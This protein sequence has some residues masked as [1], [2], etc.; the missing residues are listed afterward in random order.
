IY[1]GGMMK[2]KNKWVLKRHSVIRFFYYIV[3]YLITKIS[4]NPKIEKFR[5]SKKRQFLILFNHQTALDQFLVGLSVRRPVYF[6]ASEDIFSNGF[7]SKLL[8][9]AT[10]PI[11]IKKSTTDVSAVR[12]CMRVAREGGTIAMAPEGNRTY[13]GRTE[14]I[15]PSVAQLVK[16]LKLP[17]ALY[18]I[19]GGYGVHPRFADKTRKGYLHGGVSR[20]IEPE[21][22]LALDDDALY[23]II[24]D[25]LYV[26]DSELE[27]A[28]ESD[29]RAEYI[30]RAV[31]VCPECGLSEFES[32]KHD[33]YCKK[34]G[35]RATYTKDK[36]FVGSAGKF[37]FAN[38]REWYDYQ[39]G[40]VNSLDPSRYYE[41]AICTEHADL[42]EVTLYKSKKLICENAEISLFGN[43]Y[44][45]VANGST[46]VLPF[47]EVSATAVLGRNKLNIYHGDKLYQLKP[48]KHFNSVKYVNIY[49]RY[50]NVTGGKENDKFL[51][52]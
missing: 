40:F 30:E 5:E 32:E 15:K 46:S 7:I 48:G 35:I 37:P 18:K 23:K 22:Y 12:N 28:Y 36:K 50:K 24:C 41:N 21:E 14:Y 9:F 45:I 43:R 38:M 49:Y 20:I 2:K 42:Y 13:S 29:A 16:A 17:L 4:Y 47:D 52:L 27:N 10:A 6:V 51:G 11:P 44:E 19:E 26:D 31:Y 8:R 34:C 25:G 1:G 3:I 33:V 39:C